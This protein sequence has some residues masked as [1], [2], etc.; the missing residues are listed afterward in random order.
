MG[1]RYSAPE[2]R[3]VE[4]DLFGFSCGE[5]TLDSWLHERAWDGQQRGSARTYVI[6][7][8]D[9]RVVGYYALSAGSVIR[10]NAPGN[11]RRNMP[12]PLPV[13]VLGHLAIDST[14]HG[15][16]LGMA[17]VHDAMLRS[18]RASHAIGAVALVAHALNE[19]LRPFYQQLGFVEFPD[20]SL[21]FFLRFRDIQQVLSDVHRMYGQQAAACGNPAFPYRAQTHLPRWFAREVCS[22]PLLSGQRPTR[23]MGC[24]S[25]RPPQRC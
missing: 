11:L 4:H 13:I 14:H 7:D 2:L 16:G 21:T 6:C 23:R 17:L 9:K 8:D 3:S 20:E 19:G 24:W 10:A 25:Y 1:V 18:L 22:F 15:Q 12:D 5:P